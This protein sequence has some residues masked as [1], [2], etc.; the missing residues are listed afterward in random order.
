MKVK[1]PQAISMITKYIK[2]G[3]VPML[4]GSPGCGKS[5]IIHQIAQFYNLKLIDL[6]L[7]QC[8][9]CDLLGFPS[10]VGNKAGYKPM[11][12]FPI[13]GDPI[14]EGYSGWLLFFDEFNAAPRSVQ[15]AA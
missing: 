4:V 7:S 11:D 12:T 6:R 14:P 9:P 3:L 5:Q 8:D 10:I 1:T 2:A 15:A 13:E